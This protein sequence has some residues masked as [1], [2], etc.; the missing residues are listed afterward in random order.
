M[1]NNII[2][3]IVVINIYVRLMFEGLYNDI[4]ILEFEL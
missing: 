2:I 4:N 1:Y 3:I